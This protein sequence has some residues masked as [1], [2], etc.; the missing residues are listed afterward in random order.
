MSGTA[1]CP[2]CAAPVGAGARFCASC[3]TRL[4][5][6]PAEERKLAT[7]MFADV[8]GSTDLGDQLDP[9]RVRALL[10][11][12]FS[13]MTAIVTTWG[14]TVE[15]YIGDAIL[16]VWGVPAAREDDPVRALHA[17]REMVAELERLNDGFETRHGVRLGVRIGV[18]TGEVL[19]PVGS[20]P[21]GQFLVSGDAVNVASRLQQAADPG[22]TLVGERTWSS[23]RRAFAFS[24]PSVLPIKGKRQPI[25]ARSLGNPINSGDARTLF[26][27]PMVGREHELS[28]LMGLL[29]EAIESGSPR[30]VVVAGP[31][32]IGKSRMLR[33]M[34]AEAAELNDR[35]LV[36]RGRCLAA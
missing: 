35:L 20:R 25:S 23:A 22:T 14:G 30:L 33:E 36:L 15:K 34:I 8:T 7:I 31:A 29:D 18:N 16:A 2:T 9:E 21:G 24:P 4:G 6:A 3:G 32:G 19:A 10:Q 26:H 5:P 28:T 1:V 12:Y 13:A 17:A 27:S 11:D